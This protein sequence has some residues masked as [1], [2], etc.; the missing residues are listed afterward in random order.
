[1]HAVV[2]TEPGEPEVPRWLEVP[3]P[4]P[5]PGEVVI[6]VAASGVNHADLMQRQGRN[7]APPGAPPYPGLECSGR[8]RAVG[9]GVTGWRCGDEVC[10]AVR[11][12]L[13]GA[14]RGARR[15]ALAG[16]GPGRHRHGRRVPGDRLHGVRQR[17][18][19][20]PADRRGDPARARRKQ[21]DGTMAIQLGK[22]FGARVAC[23]AGSPQKLAR[24]RELGADLAVN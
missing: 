17:L 10:A 11:R 14:G 23:T 24:C 8:V 2:I 5:G 9:D 3:D 4:V 19:A 1:M 18:P 15:A 20:R 12:R 7:P 21:R 13:R 22:A 6:D 16:A